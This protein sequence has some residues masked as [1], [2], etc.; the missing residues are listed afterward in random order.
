MIMHAHIQHTSS[1]PVISGQ[2]SPR[3]RVLHCRSDVYIYTYTCRRLACNIERCHTVSSKEAEQFLK[4]PCRA[5]FELRSLSRLTYQLQTSL[6][7]II[8]GIPIVSTTD[9][10]S[11]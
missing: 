4:T 10:I 1:C 9:E 7:C 5:R 3:A 8:G 2:L 6:A 11:L